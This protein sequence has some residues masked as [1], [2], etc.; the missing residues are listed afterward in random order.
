MIVETFFAR[1][2]FQN[3]DIFYQ[4]KADKTCGLQWKS[5][6][7]YFEEFLP[8]SSQWNRAFYSSNF[9]ALSFGTYLDAIWLMLPNFS[10]L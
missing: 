10:I 9:I 8:I 7:Q 6:Y 4:R 5:S 3:F 1:R 2:N